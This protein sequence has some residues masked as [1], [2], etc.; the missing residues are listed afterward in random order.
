[1]L[2]V[3]YLTLRDRSGS[4]RDVAHQDW[5][6]HPMWE[7]SI[8]QLSEALL[9]DR[10][11]HSSWDQPRKLPEKRLPMF[12]VSFDLCKSIAI[13]LYGFFPL[14]VVLNLVSEFPRV[15]TSGSIALKDVLS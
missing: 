4:L 3:L 1:V 13:L 7:R 10:K 14:T 15:V 8:D 9:A 2:Y 5:N 11:S 6:L 12:Q